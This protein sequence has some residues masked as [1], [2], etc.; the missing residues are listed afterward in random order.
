VLRAWWSDARGVQRP[1]VRVPA[2][3]QWATLLW[4]LAFAGLALRSTRWR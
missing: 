4:T 2:R 3:T 1:P